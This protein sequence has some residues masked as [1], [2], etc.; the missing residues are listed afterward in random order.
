[1]ETF[2]PWQLYHAFCGGTYG[3]PRKPVSEELAAPITYLSGNAGSGFS[4]GTGI[5]VSWK[6]GDQNGKIYN[7]GSNGNIFCVTQ[8]GGMFVAAAGMTKLRLMINRGVKAIPTVFGPYPHRKRKSI[9]NI[10][11]ASTQTARYQRTAGNGESGR[12]LTVAA[13]RR[14]KEPE[15]LRA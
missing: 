3:N 4:Y 10:R 14:E 15:V 13:L 9:R 11:S 7:S 2:S 12:I 8:D 5:P 6:P 1:M